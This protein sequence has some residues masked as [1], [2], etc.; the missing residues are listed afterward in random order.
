MLSEKMYTEKYIRDLQN[1]TGNDPAL[2]ER[3]VY[4]FGL[5][6]AIKRTGLPFCFK[7]GT[8]LM[9]LLDRPRRLS[10]DIDIVVEPGTDIDIYI[11]RAREIFPFLDATE[12]VRIGKNNIEKRHF[13]I[14]YNSPVSNREVTILLDV[15][16]E[17][18]QYINTIEKPIRNELLL[19]E[20][21]D[22]HVMLPN[23]NGL[24]GDKLTAFA[25]HTTGIPFRVNK[26]L[27]I[28][29]QLFDCGTL[30]DAMTDLMEVS[31]S[32]NRTVQSELSYRGLATGPDE[33]LKD[34]IIGALCIASRG[35][36]EGEYSLYK[37]GISKI[38][39]HILGR[40]FSGEI[41]GSYA[42]KV[43]YLAASILTGQK[44]IKQ[45]EDISVYLTLSPEIEK[46]KRFS[47]LR[48]VDPAAYGYLIEAAALL[49]GTG[50]TGTS[51]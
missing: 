6:E 4:A 3:V 26:E 41:A 48:V 16:F 40:K 12:Q 24:L 30:F 7:G 29:K 18:L 45:I 32:Y 47:Y 11:R 9:L 38:R 39:N 20:G 37:E 1:R 5:L 13:K 10:T 35:N 51:L 22:L 44:T 27:E 23:V 8:S 34:T 49:Q 19:T 50:L 17:K 21:E 43:L 2:L 46:A 14:K 31:V 33:V 36:P 25:P 15:L 28:I 42:C